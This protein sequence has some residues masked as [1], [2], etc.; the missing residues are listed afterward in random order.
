MK[1][2]TNRNLNFEECERNCFRLLTR[3]FENWRK[4]TRRR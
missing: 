2:M 3:F 1:L 4:D